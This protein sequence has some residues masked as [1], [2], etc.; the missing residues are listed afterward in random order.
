MRSNFFDSCAFIVALLYS[1]IT[2]GM[3]MLG[4]YVILGEM[5]TIATILLTCY[6]LIT[7]FATLDG[8]ISVVESIMNKLGITKSMYERHQLELA[9]IKEEYEKKIEMLEKK[10]LAKDDDDFKKILCQTRQELFKPRLLVDQ[11]KLSKEE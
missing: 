9:R 2:T 1:L 8:F 5:D 3:L 6:A 4:I 11:N 10:Y 7:L